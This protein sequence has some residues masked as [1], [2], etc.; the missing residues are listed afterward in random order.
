MQVFRLAVLLD[1]TLIESICREHHHLVKV[2]AF[3]APAWPCFPLGSNTY[4]QQMF[5]CLFC[6]EW[7]MSLKLD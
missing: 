2:G 6:K 4:V 3:F 5:W 1:H 7:Y